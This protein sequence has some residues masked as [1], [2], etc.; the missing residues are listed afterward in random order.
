ML[1]ILKELCRT[2]KHRTVGSRL[3]KEV[4]LRFH[5]FYYNSE[6]W[7]RTFWFGIPTQKT[8]LD[9]F[10]YQ[11]IV[12]E[13]KPNIII[14]TGTKYGGS[15]LFL[16][17]MLDILKKG[18]VITIDIE[19]EKVPEHKRINY[20]IGSSVSD[21][22]IRAV[23]AQIKNKQKVMVILD[24]DHH[25]SY[26]LKELNVYS[27]LVTK[28]SYLIVEDTNINGNPVLPGFGPGPMEAVKEFLKENRDFIIDKS[29]EKLYLTFN[30]Q[31]YLKKIR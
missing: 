7:L 11:E 8:P 12:N 30:P 28:G 22:V 31:G 20:V 21:E 27:K 2:L 4:I 15:A 6:V 16:A 10:I 9:L 14:E 18:R 25:E 17:H 24:S 19:K 5:R 26:V 1:Q 23:K 13:I 3:N 29:R